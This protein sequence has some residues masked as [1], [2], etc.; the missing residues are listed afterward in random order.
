MEHDELRV[1]SWTGWSWQVCV[2]S[3]LHADI[4]GIG[5]VQVSQSQL[6]GLHHML[7][8]LWSQNTRLEPSSS[9][10]SIGMQIQ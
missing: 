3:D 10:T 4:I 2:S 9:P 1:L 6:H 8:M 7:Y 5:L